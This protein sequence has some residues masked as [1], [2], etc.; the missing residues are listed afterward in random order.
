[1]IIEIRERRRRHSLG[2]IRQRRTD[3]LAAIA[4][5]A[6]V[7]AVTG[8]VPISNDFYG[9]LAGLMMTVITGQILLAF[10]VVIPLPFT[11]DD[12]CMKRIAD[13]RIRFDGNEPTGQ[14]RDE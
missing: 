2:P 9:T 4:A 6:S 12:Y 3:V 11:Y 13:K 5:D 14:P 10:A 8:D 1:V 7:H